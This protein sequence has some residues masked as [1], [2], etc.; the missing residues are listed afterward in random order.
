[1][2]DQLDAKTALTD[3]DYLEILRFIKKTYQLDLSLYRKNFIL[4]HL[5]SQMLDRKCQRG[6]DYVGI[7]KEDPQEYVRFLE[8]LSINVTHFYRDAEVFQTFREKIVPLLL[9]DR[10]AGDPGLIRV[11][12]AACASG[13]EPY[14]LASLFREALQ[15]REQMLVKITASDVNDEALAYAREGVYP[16]KDFREMDKKLLDKYFE[17]VYNECYRVKDELR[18]T[19]RF[20]RHNL[21]TDEPLNYMDVIFC[22]NVMIYFS[23]QQQD[24]LLARFHRSLNSGG[25]LVLA[26]VEMAW[27]KN[28]FATIDGGCKIYQKVG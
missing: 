12:S 20:M 23:R 8:S 13:Q 17:P 14:S 3:K 10:K 26:K 11:W 24:E 9:G 28:L 2:M 7:L 1:M 4:R 25:F 27:D 18:K 15:G 16:Q 6:A 22:R 21:M 19:V 5:R